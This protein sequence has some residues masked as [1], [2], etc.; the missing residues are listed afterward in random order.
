MTDSTYHPKRHP[1]PISR[2][3]TVHFP[4]T[5]TETG[6]SD[7]S[8]P[9]SRLRLIVSDARLKSDNVGNK[10]P[11][12]RLLRRWRSWHGCDAV[13]SSHTAVQRLSICQPP[14]VQVWPHAL[15]VNTALT[16]FPTKQPSYNIII[17]ASERSETGGHTF[18]TFVHVCVREH[19]YLVCKY[20][21][22]G[23]R[24][25]LGYKGAPSPSPTLYK[26]CKKIHLADICTLW[27]PSSSSMHS[28]ARHNVN[29]AQHIYWLGQPSGC[30]CVNWILQ[31]WNCVIA[32]HYGMPGWRLKNE[33]K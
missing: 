27:A 6:I 21:E 26:S 14:V 22:N 25:K 19:S 7:R 29:T 23:L 20:L 31:N 5:H 16:N 1:D 2:F 12:V 18:F 4:D 17:S 3:A 32:I 30:V 33:G 8:I 9:K 24:W 11:C 28:M 10:S 15:A 13:W